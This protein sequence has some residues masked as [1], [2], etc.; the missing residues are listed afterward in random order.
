MLSVLAILWPATALNVHANG[1]PSYGGVNMLEALNLGEAAGLL[2]LGHWSKN[3]ESFRRASELTNAYSI[4]FIEAFAPQ[5]LEQRFPE[6]DFSPEARLTQEHADALWAQID[7]GNGFSQWAE[8]GTKHSDT[9]VAIDRWGNMTAVVHSINCV[10]W[11]KTAIIIDGISIGDPAVSQ[12]PIMAKAGPGNRLGDPTE[13]GLVVKDGEPVLAFSSMAMGLHQE[14][15]Q[16]MT[17]VLGFGMSPKEALDAPSIL[18]PQM[19]NIT[20]PTQMTQT[21][22]VMEGEFDEALLQD[23]GLPYKQI[24]A[25]DRRYAQGLWVGIA[26]DPDTGELKAASHPYTNG[27]ALALDR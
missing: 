26:R 14:T 7:A 18:Y 17:N 9:V 20:D 21:I 24:P 4:S 13:L 3:A 1:L 5:V 25:K 15:F 27:Q 2:E 23:T 11:G 22:R 12:K 19:D 16:S 6:L 8:T 10:V